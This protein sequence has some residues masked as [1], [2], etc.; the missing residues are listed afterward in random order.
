MIRKLFF[1]VIITFRTRY[2]CYYFF[3]EYDFRQ[4]PCN[5][6]LYSC[7]KPCNDFRQYPCN[8]FKSDV[9]FI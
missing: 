2:Q 1:I 3:N 6:S 8:T 5:T 7:N 9:T 4:Y